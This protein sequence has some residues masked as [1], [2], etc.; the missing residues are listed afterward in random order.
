MDPAKF[1]ACPITQP[2]RADVVAPNAGTCRSGETWTTIVNIMVSSSVK[3]QVL[4][5]EATA[6]R[7][8]APPRQPSCGCEGGR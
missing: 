2:L 4:G 3:Q 6:A 8:S 1:A 7:P 5:A